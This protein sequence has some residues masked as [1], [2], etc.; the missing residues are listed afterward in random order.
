MLLYLTDPAPFQ[1]QQ[2]QP[3]TPRRSIVEIKRKESE[4]RGPYSESL[5]NLS[6][7]SSSSVA[8]TISNSPLKSQQFQSQYR[9][10]GIVKIKNNTNL[11]KL[12]GSNSSLPDN[13]KHTPLKSMQFKTPVERIRSET[14]PAPQLR[15]KTPPQPQV[16]PARPMPAYRTQVAPQITVTPPP[17]PRE[18]IKSIESVES[19]TI[20]PESSIGRQIPIEIVNQ[21]EPT[22]VFL[23]KIE[24]AQN[25]MNSG[26]FNLVTVTDKELS[27]DEL[28]Q[29]EQEIAEA[30]R[31]ANYLSK[32]KVFNQSNYET[33]YLIGQPEYQRAQRSVYHQRRSSKIGEA[34]NER[35]LNSI[36]R[37]IYNRHRFS[38]VGNEE[39]QQQSKSRSK[40]PGIR[41]TSNNTNLSNF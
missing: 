38:L 15:P 7:P 17:T 21:P 26:N 11:S 33:D 13:G 10:R 1:Q 4:F 19:L 32:S 29:V 20:E 12:S 3:T 36:F 40:S 27:G 14:P 39:T 30:E 9:P 31:S 8:Y 28:K 2:Q 6:S 23:K 16:E 41:R 18:R 37:R 34:Q 25:H 35:E 24:T 5:T 22:R